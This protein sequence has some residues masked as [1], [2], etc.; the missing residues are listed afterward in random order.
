MDGAVGRPDDGPD[1]GPDSGPDDRAVA[2]DRALRPALCG[3]EVPAA[4]AATTG[5]KPLPCVGRVTVKK[6]STFRGKCSQMMSPTSNHHCEWPSDDSS[7]VD[8]A[9]SQ[10]HEHLLTA[11]VKKFFSH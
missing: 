1:G 3:A 4:T 11:K 8:T 5:T 2:E 6:N 9:Q 10:I 7:N